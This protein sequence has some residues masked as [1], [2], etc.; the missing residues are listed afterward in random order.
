M[1]GRPS[2]R[3]AAAA[4][5]AAV[6]GCM[7]APQPTADLA[8]YEGDPYRV[9][10]QDFK[11]VPKTLVVPRGTTVKWVNLD[12]TRHTVT[13]AE[14]ERYDSGM[15]GNRVVFEH[16]FGA[17]GRYQYL[18]VPHPGMQAEIVVE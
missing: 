8:P 18:C 12:M 1:P 9:L 14:T 15:M 5:A 16:T 17:P 2:R 6:S 10:I 7:G 13:S 3:L 11:F 4:L